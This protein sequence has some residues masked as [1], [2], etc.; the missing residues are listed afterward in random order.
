M[1]GGGDFFVSW[2]KIASNDETV[3]LPSAKKHPQHK[4]GITKGGGCPKK[5]LRGKRVHPH[6]GKTDVT[7]T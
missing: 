5:S 1:R 3:F 2:E 4:K 6:A 7:G